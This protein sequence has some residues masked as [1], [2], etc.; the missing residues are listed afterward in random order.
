LRPLPA[1][2]PREWA[3]AQEAPATAAASRAAP[4]AAAGTFAHDFVQALSTLPHRISPKYFY[5]AAGSHLFDRI[6][7]LPEYYPSWASCAPAP[8][9]WPA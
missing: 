8:G 2:D 6:C 9:T 7:E 3:I 5:D 4:N 1:L